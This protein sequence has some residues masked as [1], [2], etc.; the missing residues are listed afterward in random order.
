MSSSLSAWETAGQAALDQIE[1]AHA[2]AGGTLRG[3]RYATEF[4]NQ[5]Y[6]MLL[7]SQFQAFCRNL[8]TECA[9][10]LSS[11]IS[12][13]QAR[14]IVE[15]NFVFGRQLDKGNPH[16]GAIGADFNR[17]GIVFWDQVIAIDSRNEQR[18][19]SLE[20]M[21]A[22]R[23]AIAHQDFQQS[24]LAAM[25][26]NSTDRRLHLGDVRRWRTACQNIAKSFDEVMRAHLNVVT[27][28]YPW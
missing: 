16:P 13:V 8:H 14:A 6:V 7:S 21:N 19:L 2:S 3:R 27:G 25:I 9:S 20:L 10:Y 26:P 11:T 22:W 24:A 28:A 1:G 4:I 18:K 12:N 17:F 23:N 15:L 5:A